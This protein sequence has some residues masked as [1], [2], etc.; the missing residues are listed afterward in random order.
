MTRILII[1]ITIIALI[2]QGASAQT[3]S[4]HLPHK[5]NVSE[6]YLFYLH[7]GVVTALGN[8]AVNESMPEWGPYEYLNILD[9]LKSRGYNVVS[10]NRKEGID[11]SVYVNKIIK[12]IDSLLQAGLGARN[13]LIV[14]ASSGSHIALPIAS[15]M[16]G[17]KIKYVIMGACWPDTHKN[18]AGM[19]LY[20]HFLSIIE[21][22]DPHGTC[23]KIFEGRQDIASFREITL[24][25][26]L[27]HGF[28]YKG[29]REWINPIVA[30]AASF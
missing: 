12:Q 30:W 4:T 28:M 18:Y 14:G 21:T 8:N 29:Y 25:T 24:N 13:I 3:V 23:Q 7:G 10:E 17:K 6:K 16:K 15:R 5:I 1:P 9:S 20:G 26:G 19:A 22:T 11:D 27:S 2:S